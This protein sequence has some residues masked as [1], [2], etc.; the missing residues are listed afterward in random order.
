MRQKVKCDCCGWL[1]LLKDIDNIFVKCRGCKNEK[2]I[3]IK[4]LMEST[5]EYKA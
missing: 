4:D 2:T 1:L 5:T 3:K